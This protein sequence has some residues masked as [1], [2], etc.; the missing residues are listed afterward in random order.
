MRQL[1]TASADKT[2]KLWNLDGFILDRTL[3]GVPLPKVTS[4]QIALMGFPRACETG[5]PM[6]CDLPGGFGAELD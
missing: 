6:L 2:V 4:P 3:T 5:I 1:A